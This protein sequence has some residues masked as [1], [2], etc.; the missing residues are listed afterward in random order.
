MSVVY[1]VLVNYMRC[2]QPVTPPSQGCN[3]SCV[4]Q[5]SS[6]SLFSLLHLS[7]AMFLLWLAIHSVSSGQSFSS[8]PG[9]V[10]VNLGTSLTLPCTVV[11]RRGQVQW[12]RDNFGLGVDRQLAGFSRYS[13]VGAGGEEDYSLNISGVTIEDDAT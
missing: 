5:S 10:T 12:T 3:Q 4:T 6:S 13:M 7:L 9:D 1:C 8:Q 11:D 2:R